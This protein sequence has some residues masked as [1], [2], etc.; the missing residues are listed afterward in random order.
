MRA[1]SV[2]G[3]AY[4]LTAYL[5]NFFP[6]DP[7]SERF[8]TIAVIGFFTFINILGLHVGT[9]VQNTLTLLPRLF[10]RQPPRMR[11]RS[12]FCLPARNP[13]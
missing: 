9:R 4:I 6:M 10:F 3:V 13:F 12:P 5:Q 8:V 2:A 7:A 1:G 11:L